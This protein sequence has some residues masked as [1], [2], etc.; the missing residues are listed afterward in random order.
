[1][2]GEAG[3]AHLVGGSD[4]WRAGKARSSTEGGRS[5]ETKGTKGVRVWLVAPFLFIS[6][7]VRVV[8]SRMNGQDQL[9]YLG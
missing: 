4:Q 8:E 6:I 7:L 3:L 5:G 9:G 2:G 1:V